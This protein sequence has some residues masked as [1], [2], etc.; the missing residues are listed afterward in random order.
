MNYIKYVLRQRWGNDDTIDIISPS[1]IVDIALRIDDSHDYLRLVKEAVVI[2]NDCN[3]FIALDLSLDDNREF[4]RHH[5]FE[6]VFTDEYAQRC[7][8]YQ[9][10]ECKNE[11][12]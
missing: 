9:E 2:V 7:A 5:V 8:E 3:D 4:I 12:A 11:I 10:M 6:C 1:P